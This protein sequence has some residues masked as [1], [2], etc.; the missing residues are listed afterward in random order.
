LLDGPVAMGLE[1]CV[2]I[3]CT[4]LFI[5]L[6]ARIRHIIWPWYRLPMSFSCFSRQL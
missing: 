4:V 3:V 1:E 6:T 5:H 2:L